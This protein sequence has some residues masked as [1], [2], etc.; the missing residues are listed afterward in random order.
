MND[1]GTF[2]L[3]GNTLKDKYSLLH[4][5]H[6]S[7]NWFYDPVMSLPMVDGIFPLIK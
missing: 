7:I 6:P 2:K 1:Q 3:S 5:T 4:R